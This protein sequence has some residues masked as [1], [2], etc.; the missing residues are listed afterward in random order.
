MNCP[1]CHKSPTPLNPIK[2]VVT[3]ISLCHCNPLTLFKSL[4]NQKTERTGQQR[5]QG[6]WLTIHKKEEINQPKRAFKNLVVFTANH[7]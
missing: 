7:H 2:Y 3:L 1:N 4:H 5:G 6:T